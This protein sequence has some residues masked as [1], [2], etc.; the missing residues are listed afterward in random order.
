MHREI[1]DL[2]VGAEGGRRA[3]HDFIDA[4][5]V[6]D[7]RDRIDLVVGDDDQRRYG[8]AVILMPEINGDGDREEGGGEV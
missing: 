6:R 5:Q 7:A 1:L 2:A 8:A 4:E 3:H